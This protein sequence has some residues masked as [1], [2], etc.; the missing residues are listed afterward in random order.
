MKKKRLRPSRLIVGFLLT[1]QNIMKIALT[2]PLRG[3]LPLMFTGI[4]KETYS[5]YSRYALCYINS[6]GKHEYVLV[7]PHEITR[8]AGAIASINDV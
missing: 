3:P 1:E 6:V 7:K 5:D 4:D 8:I 2:V